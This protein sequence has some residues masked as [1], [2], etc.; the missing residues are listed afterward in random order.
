MDTRA[1]IQD[2]YTNAPQEIKNF[3]AN[4]TW[5][6]KLEFVAKSNDFSLDSAEYST[7]RLEL[8]FVALGITPVEILGSAL[9]KELDIS[10]SQAEKLRQDI[11]TQILSPILEI[12]QSTSTNL[13]S[14]TSSVKTSDRTDL[15]VSQ[16]TEPMIIPGEV[17][18][19]TPVPIK[20][21]VPATIP[22]NLPMASE[23]TIP[24]QTVATAPKQESTPDIFNRH[25]ILSDI[26][27]PAPTV[28]TP[29]QTRTVPPATQKQQAEPTLKNPGTPLYEQKLNQ[30]VRL[31]RQEQKITDPYR[32]NLE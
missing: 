26:E 19:D 2:Y 6:Q 23:P 15:I 3:L 9:A 28:F 8:L 4:D 27:N 11:V 25:D 20:K 7:L 30:T 1:L 12:L 17:V 21:A 16:D 14:N 13:S 22:T 24:Q 10:L 32:E 5:K 31:P 29:Q 18:H